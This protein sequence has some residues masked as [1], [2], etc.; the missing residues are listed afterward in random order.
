MDA[1]TSNWPMKVLNGFKVAQEG[2]KMGQEDPKVIPRSPQVGPGWPQDGLRG[3]QR[4]HKEGPRR[5]QGSPKRDKDEAKMAQHGASDSKLK[6]KGRNMKNLENTKGKSM[7][8]EAPGSPGK[9]NMR[10]RW[11]QVSLKLG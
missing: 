9:P 7:F 3:P 11:L 4:W 6:P 1:K 2:H 8:F 5:P 10:P